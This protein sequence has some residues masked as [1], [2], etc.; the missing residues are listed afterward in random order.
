MLA[1]VL[2]DFLSVILQ[3]ILRSILK[4]ELCG[5]GRNIKESLSCQTHLVP[6]DLIL[7]K[8]KKIPNA[9]LMNGN[10][11]IAGKLHVWCCSMK[12]LSFTL[13]VIIFLYIQNR[14]N[15]KEEQ[16]N[17]MI[18]YF[19]YHFSVRAIADNTCVSYQKLVPWHHCWCDW[20]AV[21]KHSC[22]SLID[23]TRASER[24]AKIKTWECVC[25][26]VYV[27]ILICCLSLLFYLH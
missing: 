10:I 23:L 3:T 19:F 13:M 22:P 7:K 24:R 25:A 26:C 2:V 20:Q 27:Y 8:K 14:V 1:C 17:V 15:L 21:R 9:P 18:L 12:K 6:R 4:A 11:V 5:H 16:L